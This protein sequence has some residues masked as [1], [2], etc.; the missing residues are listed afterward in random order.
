MQL[1]KWLIKG[2]AYLFPKQWS[3]SKVMS[4]INQDIKVCDYCCKIDAGLNHFTSCKHF[5]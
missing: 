3:K 1:I 2:K 4:Y 5:Q